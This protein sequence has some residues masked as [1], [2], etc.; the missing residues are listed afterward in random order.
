MRYGRAR[1]NGRQTA[2][3]DATP[4][5]PRKGETEALAQ[6]G[7]A[8]EPHVER[9]QTARG[10][11]NR[12]VVRPLLSQYDSKQ[13]RHDEPDKGGFNVIAFDV[14]RAEHVCSQKPTRTR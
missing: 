4:L 11:R 5:Q 6:R 1:K 12:R 2:G 14:L 3:L 9:I 7:H 8:V 13:T 10:M